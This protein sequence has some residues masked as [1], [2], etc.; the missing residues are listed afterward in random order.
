MLTHNYVTFCG[1]FLCKE[2]NLQSS[3]EYISQETKD[4][5]H[6]LCEKNSGAEFRYCLN[7]SFIYEER[8]GILFP[9][10]RPPLEALNDC[11]NDSVSR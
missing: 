4:S 11:L 8:N 10:C 1:P 7:D 3:C 9:I 6:Q 2:E 5:F